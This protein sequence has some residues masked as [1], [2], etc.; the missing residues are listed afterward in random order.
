M[1]WVIFLGAYFSITYIGMVAGAFYSIYIAY[2]S[3]VSRTGVLPVEAKSPLFVA[4][5]C[6]VNAVRFGFY[7]FIGLVA[8]GFVAG[9]VFSLWAITSE[10]GT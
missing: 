8:L 3:T 10:I 9:V 7:T 2:F 4:Y 6:I 1:G 5:Q